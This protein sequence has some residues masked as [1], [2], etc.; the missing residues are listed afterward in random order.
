MCDKVDK[1]TKPFAKDPSH[2]LTTEAYTRQ[3]AHSL[4][5]LFIY[6]TSNGRDY[7][8]A[9]LD[10]LCSHMTLF[11]FFHITVVFFFSCRGSVIQSVSDR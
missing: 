2:M 11:P 6:T 4:T 7:M 3:K 8:Q 10:L 1:E 5:M 9:D